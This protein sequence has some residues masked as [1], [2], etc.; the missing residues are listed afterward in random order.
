MF[1]KFI[2]KKL[3]GSKL[4]GMGVTDDQI[5]MIIELVNKNPEL[6]KKIQAE[7]EAKK[8]QG[9]P[10]QAAMMTVMREHQAELQALMQKK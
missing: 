8:K 7:V 2:L 6:F 9:I 5:D 1:Q 10:E 3:L 4:K